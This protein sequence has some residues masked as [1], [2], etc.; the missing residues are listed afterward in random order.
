MNKYNNL[1]THTVNSDGQL[2]V[3]QSIKFCENNNVGAIAFTDHDAVLQSSDIKYLKNYTGPVRWVSGVEISVGKIPELEKQISSLHMVGLFVDPTNKKLQDFCRKAQ[4]ARQERMRRII[5]NLKTIDIH[6]TEEDC[7]EASGG[8]TVG[9]PHIVNAI[10]KYQKNID[11]INNLYER[12]KE[13][14]K[15]NEELKKKI[16]NVEK[17]GDRQKSFE[18]FLTEESYISDIYV[19][20]LFQPTWDECVSVIRH[21]GGLSFLAHYFVYVN[22]LPLE[23]VE[24][25]LEEDRLDGLEVVYGLEE[26]EN[27]ESNGAR[28]LENQQ[29]QLKEIAK[30]TDSLISG[31]SDVHSKEDFEKFVSNQYYAG[32]TVGLLDNLLEKSEKDLR[33]YK[34]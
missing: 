29:S 13:E 28:E 12:M 31:G 1:H 4:E 14:S 5:E 3:P 2:T 8:E 22:K 25:L 33:W 10:L 34:S 20:Y 11:V 27:S 18:L 9:R 21:A 30:R 16:K 17:Y 32:K 7:L 26:F 15:E 24:K 6:I 23:L 19:N